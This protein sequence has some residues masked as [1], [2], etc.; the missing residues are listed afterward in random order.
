MLVR[1]IGEF[2]LGLVCYLAQRS[3]RTSVV[4]VAVDV[5]VVVVVVVIASIFLL[6]AVF[7]PER[8]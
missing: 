4:T 2:A 5:V 8:N 3:C 7:S 1:S 6:R